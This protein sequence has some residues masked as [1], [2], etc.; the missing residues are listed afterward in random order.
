MSVSYHL[1]Y[2][3]S[4]AYND[5]VKAF[6]TNLIN[7][8]KNR[9]SADISSG[10]ASMEDL[11]GLSTTLEAV[12]RFLYYNYKV[13]PDVFDNTLNTISSNLDTIACLPMNNRGIYGNTE[14][15]KKTVF[16]NPSLPGSKHLSNEERIAL[17][18]AHELGHI[19]NNTWMQRVI[20]SLNSMIQRKEIS[21]ADAQ[22]VYDGF[23]MLDEAT[24]QDRAEDFAYTFARRRYRPSLQNYR[25]SS[26]YNGETYIAS[27][28]NFSIF[29]FKFF[30]WLIPFSDK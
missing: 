1:I 5:K 22:L 10:M 27:I 7:N 25:S 19:I 15:E 29:S 8:S 23:S 24:T 13:Y 26:L 21:Q 11:D 2:D 6:L 28:S 12:E 17:Y 14:T 16:I 3:F 20:A 18:T 30:D 4:P 9:F